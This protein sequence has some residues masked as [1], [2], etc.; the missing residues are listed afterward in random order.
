M[1]T[2]DKAIEVQMLLKEKEQRILMLEQQLTREKS[3][4]QTELQVAQIHT[5]FEQMP[6]QHHARLVERDARIQSMTNNYK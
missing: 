1:T 5:K 4:Q 6:I 3:N 2:I